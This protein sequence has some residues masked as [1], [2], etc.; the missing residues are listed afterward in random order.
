LIFKSIIERQILLRQSEWVERAPRVLSDVRVNLGSV[1]EARRIAGDEDAELE[2]TWAHAHVEQPGR[3]LG[4][5]VGLLA[6]QGRAFFLGAGAEGLVAGLPGDLPAVVG[7]ADG[8][9]TAVV[10]VVAPGTAADGV[11][12]SADTAAVVA[13]ADQLD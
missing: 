7:L 8:V 13:A 12:H 11:K 3:I 1:H 6:A 10:G 5:G 9:A 2:V 4:L